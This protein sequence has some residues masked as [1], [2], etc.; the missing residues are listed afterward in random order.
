VAD[1][2]AGAAGA[3][4]AAA[5]VAADAETM[6]DR[7]GVSVVSSRGEADSSR[8]VTGRVLDS[9][10]VE[11]LRAGVKRLSSAVRGADDPNRGLA[12]VWLSERSKLVAAGFVVCCAG[13]A[14]SGDGASFGF[15]AVLAAGVDAG[16]GLL[17]VNVTRGAEPAALGCG[18]ALVS[19]SSTSLKRACCTAAGL[20]SGAA[21]S[22]GWAAAKSDVT[23]GGARNVDCE[24]YSSD[25][26]RRLCETSDVGVSGIVRAYVVP[27][28]GA[29]E[30][31][32]A[33]DLGYGSR[34]AA[35]V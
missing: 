3:G 10:R 8:M 21:D 35:E 23:A 28:Y 26:S 11:V 34:D 7:R 5:P 22:A 20:R 12:E 27:L 13:K 15:A 25:G 31:K 18:G 6:S 16:V 30:V 9:G 2:A 29:G 17:M 32:G 4:A 19:D 24:V 1:A 33:A 14:P